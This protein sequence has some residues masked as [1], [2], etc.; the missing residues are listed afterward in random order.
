MIHRTRS[1]AWVPTEASAHHRPTSSCARQLLASGALKDELLA[2][3]PHLLVFTNAAAV[4]NLCEILSPADVAALRERATA[5]SIGPVTSR[6]LDGAGFCV[7]VEPARHDVA[8]LV[9]AIC[10]WWGEQ[11]D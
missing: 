6:T 3:Q 9:E 8:H 11:K 7:A 1:I 4:R 5:A 2:Y 10:N